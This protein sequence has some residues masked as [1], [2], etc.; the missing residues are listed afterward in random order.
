MVTMQSPLLPVNP[1]I[2]SLLPS[3]SSGTMYA[4]MP[5]PA[6]TE[7]SAARFAVVLARV[8]GAASSGPQLVVRSRL[9]SN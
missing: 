4:S 8:A 1:E 2:H 7:R 3:S 6:M 9:E 5:R